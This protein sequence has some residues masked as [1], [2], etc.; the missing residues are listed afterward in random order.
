MIPKI[1]IPYVDKA[2]NNMRKISHSINIQ[3]RRWKF[4]PHKLRRVLINKLDPGNGIGDYIQSSALVNAL[5]EASPNV[6]ISFLVSGKEELK[7]FELFPYAVSV[8]NLHPSNINY[9]NLSEFAGTKLY[10][11]NFDLVIHGYGENPQ[12]MRLI[13]EQGN[14]QNSIGYFTKEKQGRFPFLTIP[15]TYNFKGVRPFSYDDYLK[16]ILDVKL[17]WKVNLDRSLLKC[18]DIDGK[19]EKANKILGIHPGCNSNR[20]ETRW[21]IKNFKDIALLFRNQIGGRVLVFGGPEE[22]EDVR[23]LTN[24]IG[25]GEIQAILNTPL[26]EVAKLISDCNVFVSNDSGLMNIS[27][28]LGVPSIG[29]LGPTDLPSLKNIYPNALFVMIIIFPVLRIMRD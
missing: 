5:K 27:M 7:V 2:I 17:D 8:I 24:E 12:F 10:A 6:E 29:I 28:A 22:E 1:L 25:D 20:K 13:S 15:T 9:N 19:N 16:K 23:K 21:H 26:L 18:S 3:L 14:I 4:N 11:E